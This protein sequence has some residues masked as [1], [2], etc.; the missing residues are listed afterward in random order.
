MEEA[1]GLCAFCLRQGGSYRC[2]R[3]SRP[4][5][6]VSC[7]S[8]DAH[9]DCSEGFYKDAFMTRLRSTHA[10]PDERRRMLDA[11]RRVE[12]EHAATEEAPDEGDEGPGEAAEAAGAPALAGLV[13]R[14]RGLEVHDLAE[15]EL[16]DMLSAE[17]QAA[18]ATMVES[19]ELD[20]DSILP[21]WTP[22]WLTPA[23]HEAA[24]ARKAPLVT[25]LGE[26]GISSPPEDPA[27][28]ESAPPEPQ[29]Q[30]PPPLTDVP[31]LSSLLGAREP[32]PL[33]LFGLVDLLVSYAVVMRFLNGDTHTSPLSAFAHLAT[34]SAALAAASPPVGVMEAVAGV[35]GR[36]AQQRS[37]LGDP[38]V[39]AEALDDAICILR[40]PPAAL[41]VLAD[42]SR[43]AAAA[44]RAAPSGAKQAGSGAKRA[45][46]G[47]KAKEAQAAERKIVFYAS[48]WTW[49]TGSEASAAAILAAGI[50]LERARDR[51]HAVSQRSS[52]RIAEL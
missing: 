7:Y 36:L 27:L 46:S 19:G 30:P 43:I 21:K 49:F 17:E 29:P 50:E 20:A 1:G 51:P 48:W 24:G 11:L 23:L 37:A 39:L 45:G 15:E 25:V 38:A 34:A 44:R 35:G 32:S 6:S 18:F 26:P 33:L 8:C 12:D 14:L 22:W 52:P 5:C 10:A 16:W 13:E 47:A 31:P 4:Y 3:C 42:L 2:P 40:V 28:P 9:A 41:R